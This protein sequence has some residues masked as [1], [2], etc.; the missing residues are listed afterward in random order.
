MWTVMVS[1]VYQNCT[2]T[3]KMWLVQLYFFILWC[4]YRAIT[5]GSI[6]PA[7][8]RDNNIINLNIISYVASHI[9]CSFDYYIAHLMLFL[10]LGSP[11]K[12]VVGFLSSE[13]IMKKWKWLKFCCY[14]YN[15]K[16]LHINRIWIIFL[17][18][19]SL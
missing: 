9:F 16:S 11:H 14:L 2:G 3:Q 1:T 12:K 15:K 10:R 7:G 18:I 19:A 8:H 5:V 6:L 17:F 4:Y 13:I